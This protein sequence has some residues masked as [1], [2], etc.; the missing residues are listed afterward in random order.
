MRLAPH[1]EHHQPVVFTGE[2]DLQEVHRRQRDT[3]ITGWFLA[4]QKYLS[5]RKLTYTNFP[6]EFVL[7]KFKREWTERLKAH[8]NMS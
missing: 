6:D 3:T 4:N 1:L 7:N 5:A 8:G 2:S